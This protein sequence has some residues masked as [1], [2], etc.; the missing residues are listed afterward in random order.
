MEKRTKSLSL[1]NTKIKKCKSP[2]SSIIVRLP[3]LTRTRCGTSDCIR[4]NEKAPVQH[5]N[6]KPVPLTPRISGGSCKYGSST[7]TC[8]VANHELPR[9][10]LFARWRSLMCAT[11]GVDLFSPFFMGVVFRKC[12]HRR[13][14]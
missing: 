3:L 11:W 6:T 9:N 1:S 5:R 2:N 10:G 14:K 13:Y 8:H 12:W 4:T 7:A